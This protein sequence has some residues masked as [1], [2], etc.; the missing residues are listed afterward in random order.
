MTRNAPSETRGRAKSP[1][2][3]VLALKLGACGT[4][5][6]LVIGIVTAHPIISG[7]SAA[8]LVKVALECQRRQALTF[9]AR[10]GVTLSVAY[11]LT[12]A[13]FRPLRRPYVSLSRWAFSKYAEAHVKRFARPQNPVE[14]KTKSGEKET[15][16]NRVNRNGVLPELVFTACG[17]YAALPV[18]SSTES[19]TDTSNYATPEDIAILA[20]NGVF[21]PKSKP[22]TRGR[23]RKSGEGE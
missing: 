15:N 6:L 4:A 12:R 14:E 2:A 17:R 8:L 10:L 20:E 23:K 21:S 9:E 1:S 16:E 22:K 7:L 3:L 19:P 11:A 18:V 13:I 5:F